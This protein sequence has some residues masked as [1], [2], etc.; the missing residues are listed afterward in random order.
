LGY[1]FNATVGEK[2]TYGGLA[3]IRFEAEIELQAEPGQF[4]HVL[5][6]D[7]AGRILRRPYSVFSS[8]QA[9]FSLLVKRVG[10]GSEWLASREAGEKIDCMGPLGNGFSFEEGERSMLI[11]GG[12][13]LAPLAFLFR[14][15]RSQGT[16]PLL[17]WG[18]EGATEYGNLP[19]QIV[20][21]F[22]AKLSCEDGSMGF[23]GTV[24]ELFEVEHTGEIDCVYACGPRAM[25]AAIAEMARRDAVQA[26]FSMEE[27]MACGIGACKG[28]AVPAYDPEGSYLTVCKDGPV[29]DG[30]ELDWARM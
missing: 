28:C 1:R 27:R 21:E 16:T 4:V 8:D 7:A 2:T 22:A 24:L 17:F 23:G 29:F 5:C 12:V 13:G 19:G 3:L 10:P 25:L 11:A 26:Q 9:V 15:M 20:R 18:I 6:G 14:R 30:K